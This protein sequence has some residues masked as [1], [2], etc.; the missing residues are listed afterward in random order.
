[1]ARTQRKKAT[2]GGKKGAKG[3]E[4]RVD[5]PTSAG[6]GVDLEVVRALRAAEDWTGVIA[7]LGGSTSAVEAEPEAARALCRA[8]LHADAPDDAVVTAAAGALDDQ[9]VDGVGARAR[10]ALLASDFEAASK[11]ALAALNLCHFKDQ[12]ILAVL[13]EAQKSL[14]SGAAEVRFAAD[15]SLC[16]CRTLRDPAS[17]MTT[18][19]IAD[20][21]AQPVDHYKA[22][23]VTSDAPNEVLKAARKAL[24]HRAGSDEAAQADAALAFLLDPAKRADYDGQRARK[25]T[26]GGGFDLNGGSDLLRQIGTALGLKFPDGFV[27]PKSGRLVRPRR[28]AASLTLAQQFG[29]GCGLEYTWDDRPSAD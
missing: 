1:M 28:C 6:D 9:D 16:A 26:R 3:A 2:G 27:F 22:L 20:A 8:F 24:K 23:F 4:S 7:L 21:V 10:L 12:A 25:L 11:H 15:V 29:G 17:A 13:Q 5:L 18:P 14:H 19:G